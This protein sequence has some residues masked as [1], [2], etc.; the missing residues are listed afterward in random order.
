MLAAAGYYR[1]KLHWMGKQELIDG[2]FGWFLKRIGCIP[3]DPELGINVHSREAKTK[4]LLFPSCACF[5]CAD[6]QLEPL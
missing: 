5:L 4:A 2:P 1:V 6:A 3:V